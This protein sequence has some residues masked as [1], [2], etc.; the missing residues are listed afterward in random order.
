MK[1]CKQ[2][3]P[4]INEAKRLG[5]EPSLT[6]GGHLKLSRR[7]CPPVFCSATPSDHRTVKNGIALLRRAVRQAH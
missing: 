2:N 6:R 1:I 7:G 5:F 4:L 3:R